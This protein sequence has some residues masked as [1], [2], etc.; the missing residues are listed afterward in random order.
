MPKISA[1]TYEKKMVF[2]QQQYIMKKQDSIMV[3]KS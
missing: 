2:I 1:K 3:K